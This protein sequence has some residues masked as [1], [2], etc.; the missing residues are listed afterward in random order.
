MRAE[1]QC[2]GSPLDDVAIRHQVE[3]LDRLE[4]GNRPIERVAG[5]VPPEPAVVS[6]PTDASARSGSGKSSAATAARGVGVPEPE[7]VQ[8]LVRD[9]G[10]RPERIAVPSSVAS[11]TPERGPGAYPAPGAHANTPST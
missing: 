10:G 2:A 1:I 7:Q 9:D 4:V 8:R 5:D 6:S 3:A 11:A